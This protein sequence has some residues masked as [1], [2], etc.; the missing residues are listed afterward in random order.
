MY[1]YRHIYRNTNKINIFFKKEVDEIST[2]A[3]F[4]DLDILR[5]EGIPKFKHVI[6]G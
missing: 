3:P 6:S 2:I 1:I 5:V 4:A